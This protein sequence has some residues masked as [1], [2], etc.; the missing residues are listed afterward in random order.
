MLICS[1]QGIYLACKEFAV[2]DLSSFTRELETVERIILN[3]KTHSGIMETLAILEHG[4]TYSLFSDLA[5]C[6]LSV[7][8]NDKKIPKPKNL[9][10]KKAIYHRVIEIAEA[11]TYLHEDLET[12]D[13]KQLRC[14]H[15]DLK[16]QNILVFKD[17]EGNDTWKISDFGISKVKEVSDNRESDEI[18]FDNVFEKR[19]PADTTS[20]TGTV[21]HRFAGTYTP[22]EAR[23]PHRKMDRS[24][25]WWSFGCVL[26]LVMTYLD[27]GARAVID[28]GKYRLDGPAEGHQQLEKRHDDM[29]YTVDSKTSDLRVND[30]VLQWFERLR[31]HASGKEGEQEIVDRTLTLV[32]DCMLIPDQRKRRHET[33]RKD[34]IVKEL[35]SIYQLFP[36]QQAEKSTSEEPASDS[37]TSDHVHQSDSGSEE[38]D[39]VSPEG[40]SSGG[41]P[42]MHHEKRK[43]DQEADETPP[44]K[45]R[46]SLNDLKPETRS[47]IQA[48]E[49]QPFNG[50]AGRIAEKQTALHQ[51]A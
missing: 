5:D 7:W 35:K 34:I 15:L 46:K 45:R 33:S 2:A 28:F 9:A 21:D 44:E 41:T 37:S 30:Y 29:F 12:D 51:L 16:P 26:I 8:L 22:P 36:E 24:S 4:D 39:L 25:D 11:L 40:T 10:E 43:S 27:G 14:Y 1:L 18:D 23:S 13:F 6:D 42:A 38:Q 31:E 17:S 3:V 49:K 48:T 32:K 47:S 20:E 50:L 19:R